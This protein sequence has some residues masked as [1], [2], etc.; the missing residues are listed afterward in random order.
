MK[1][2]NSFLKTFGLLTAV[3]SGLLFSSTVAN[4]FTVGIAFP[5]QNDTRWYTE[6]FMLNNKLK[7]AGF[8]TELFFAGDLD[9][10][11]Q[12]KQLTRML[13]SNVDILVIA[14]I[15]GFSLVDTLKPA[16]DKKLPIISYD[17]LIMNTDAPTY[18]ASVDSE[19][20]GELQGQYII[21]QLQPGSGSVKQIE[22][23]TGSPDD[24]NAR[25]F[26]EGAMKKLGGFIDLGY[27]TVKSGEV[28]QEDT[29]IQNWSPDLAN[30][31]MNDLLDKVGYGPNGERLD[32][33]LAPSDAIA[34]GIV[35]AL[36]KRGYTADN[37]PKI[38][39]C[40]STP[41]A[42][43]RIQKGEQGMTIYKS[44]ELCDTVVQMV[45]DISQGKPVDVND[46]FTYDNGFKIMDSVLCK[47]ELVDNSNV[48]IVKNY[49]VIDNSYT[50]KYRV[51]VQAQ[52][53]NNRLSFFL[54]LTLLSCRTTFFPTVHFHQWQ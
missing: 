3:I 28:K 50:E 30:K 43:E 31:R 25:I 46:N 1:I 8:N 40:D 13:N 17:R 4:A 45:K 22:I 33:I 10:G 6:G 16:Q 7:A 37:M 27:I 53:E 23:F 47:P 39:G 49:Q 35:F 18:Y 14:S 51:K 52:S 44:N 54:Q 9:N 15:D 34:D 21:D 32:A 19:M 24:N 11:L 2:L 48:D 29:A 41:A 5:T 36:K 38:T 42:L 26:Y 20:I 12:L